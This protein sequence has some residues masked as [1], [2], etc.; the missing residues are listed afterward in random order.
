VSYRI[1]VRPLVEA[2]ILEAMAWYQGRSPGLERAFYRAYLD[3]LVLVSEAPELYQK[4]RGDVRRVVFRRFPM[5]SSTS[6][7]RTKS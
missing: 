3:V 6:R 4:V 1:R 5:P 7:R 2:E